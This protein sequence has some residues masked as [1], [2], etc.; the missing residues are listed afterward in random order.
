MFG[1]FGANYSRS[2]DT[3]IRVKKKDG[4]EFYLPIADIL[5]IAESLQAEM[6]VKELEKKIIFGRILDRE[7]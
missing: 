6:A 4:K 5:K 3:T 7:I 1:I 2:D